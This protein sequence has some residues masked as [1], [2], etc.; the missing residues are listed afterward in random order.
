MSDNID[1]AS[2]LEQRDRDIAI[3]KATAPKGPG[4]EDISPL[5]QSLGARLCIDCQEI[6]EA[7]EKQRV[8][9]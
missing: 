5:R 3:A 8:G 1:H 4:G 2:D 9:R 7:T 6:K